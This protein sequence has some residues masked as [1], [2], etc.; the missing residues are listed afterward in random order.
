MLIVATFGL[1]GEW[2]R[3]DRLATRLVTSVTD[4][5]SASVNCTDN[6]EYIMHAHGGLPPRGAGRPRRPKC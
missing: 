3:F 2:T 5:A 1:L 6:R 4:L